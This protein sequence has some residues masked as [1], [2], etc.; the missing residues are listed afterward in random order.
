[1]DLYDEDRVKVEK[2]R[3]VITEA[4]GGGIHNYGKL[5]GQRDLF[6]NQHQV[7]DYDNQ[8]KKLDVKEKFKGLIELCNIFNK[9]IMSSKYEYKCKY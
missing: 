4:I 1:M 8:R 3:K 5:K 2:L 6:M 7:N 9:N